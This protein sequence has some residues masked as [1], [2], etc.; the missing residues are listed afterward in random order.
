[1]MVLLERTFKTLSFLPFCHGQGHLPL[2]QAGESTIH[3]GLGQCQGWQ[4]NVNN[5]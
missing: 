1:M 3:P 5:G 4:K 2:D